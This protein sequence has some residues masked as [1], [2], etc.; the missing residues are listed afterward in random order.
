[1][2]RNVQ[3]QAKRQ[4]RKEPDRGRLHTVR[5]STIHP[6]AAAPF[7]KQPPPS[8]AKLAPA[9]QP[10]TAVTQPSTAVTH[11]FASQPKPVASGAVSNGKKHFL[12]LV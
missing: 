8:I 6:A 9:V 3:K 12:F 1:M 4:P 5:L 7:K 2:L 10:S 11:P